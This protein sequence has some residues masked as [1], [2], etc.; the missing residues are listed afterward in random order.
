LNWVRLDIVDELIVQVY[1]ENLDHFI[2]KLSRPEMEEVKQKIPAGIGVMAGL[3]TKPV[4]IQQIQSQVRAAQQR[5]LGVAFFYYES[6]WNTA[7]GALKERLA[8]FKSLF[9]YP[10]LR[11]AVEPGEGE[12]KVES[13]PWETNLTVTDKIPF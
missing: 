6:L 12:T 8:G 1:K 11:T 9:P 7:P 4:S 5:G 2:G 3:R 13:V 10:A